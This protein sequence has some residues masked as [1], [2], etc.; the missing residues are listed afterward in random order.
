MAIAKRQK[1]INLHTPDNNKPIGLLELGEIAVKHDSVENGRLFID[2]VAN[3]EGTEETLVEFVPKTY[4]DSELEKVKSASAADLTSKI[5]SLDFTD[6]KVEHQFVTEVSEAD[7]VIS[8]SRAALVA[9][10]VPTLPQSKIT[11]LVSDLSSKVN[12]SEKGTAA[13]VSEAISGSTKLAQ[14]KLVYD[15]LSQSKTYTDGE[16]TKLSTALTASI[17][18][19]SNSVDGDINDLQSQIDTLSSGT[20]DSIAALDAKIGSGFTSTQTVKKTIDDVKASLTG[21]IAKTIDHVKVNGTELAIA[22]KSVNIEL[23]IS[24]DSTAKKIYLEGTDGTELGSI[25]TADFV[26]DGMVSNVAYDHET[27]TLTIT[28]NTDSGKEAIDVD[29]SDLVDVYTAGNG[30]NVANNV[31]SAKLDSASESFLTIGSGGIKLS[32]VQAAI[33]A[34]VTSGSTEV[35]DLK[36]IIGEGFTSASTV[37][38]QLAAVKTTADSAVKAASGDTYVSASVAGNSVNVAATDTLT[39]A[40]SKAN[41]AVQSITADSGVVVSGDTAK[42]ISFANF[43]MDAGTF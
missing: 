6:T 32:G 5:E 26:K 9:D 1:I 35:N 16:I 25:D 17:S 13:A 14:E 8:V 33:N 11:N 38:S 3:G 18:D 22:D 20:T 43:V 19:L 41:S 30:I 2:T 37:S 39:S 15:A 12:N 4:I 40:V 42:A 23:G 27:Q 7:G 24:Y 10:D 28:F 21:E 31:I 34:A 36:A 29:L